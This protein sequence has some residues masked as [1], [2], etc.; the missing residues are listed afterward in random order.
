MTGAHGRADLAS[1]TRF[2]CLCPELTSSL[3]SPLASLLA[4]SLPPPDVALQLEKLARLEDCERVKSK[5]VCL[6]VSFP[7]L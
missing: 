1:T 2:L 5:S 3:A 6:S 7:P 4:S